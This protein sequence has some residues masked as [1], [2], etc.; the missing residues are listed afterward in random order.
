MSQDIEIHL[1]TSLNYTVIMPHLRQNERNRAFGMFVAGTSVN[2]FQVCFVA[3][4]L[5]FITS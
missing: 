3:L 2:K 5:L 1:I 4:V